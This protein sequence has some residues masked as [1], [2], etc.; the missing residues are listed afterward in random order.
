MG[1]QP[2]AYVERME[3]PPQ[4][5]TVPCDCSR[6]GVVK[7]GHYEVARC[8][9]CNCQFWAVQPKRNGPLVIRPWPGLPG[10]ERR[11]A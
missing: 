1:K 8:P 3:I 5:F 6:K 4:N 2:T 11:A 7:L 9:Q 10:M